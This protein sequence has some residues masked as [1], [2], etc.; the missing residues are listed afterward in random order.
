MLVT[1][2]DLGKQVTTMVPDLQELSLGEV[3]GA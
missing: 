3:A 2:L 1:A